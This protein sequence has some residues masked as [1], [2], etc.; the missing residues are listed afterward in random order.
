MILIKEYVNFLRDHQGLCKESIVIRKLH[1]QRFLDGIG[2]YSNLSKFRTISPPIIH[3]YI[4]KTIHN[5][6]RSNR[7]QVISS[8]RSFL[9][10]AYLRGFLKTNLV[11][12]VP[13]IRTAR[14][15][16][17]PRGYSW[18]SVKALLRA[19]DRTTPSGRRDYAIL[20]LLAS[21]GV[22]NRQ[23]ILLKLTDIKWHA[24]TIDFQSLKGGK[25]LCFPLKKN[26]AI[27]LLDY[28]KKD[29]SKET[30]FNEVFLLVKGKTRPLGRSVGYIVKMYHER[31]KLKNLYCGPHAIRHA[32]A[33]HLVE[34]NT[35][36]KTV[37]DLLGHSSIDTT[38]IYT[39]VDLKHLRV[40]A[41]QWPG[42]Q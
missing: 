32:F 38:F 41:R 20:Q 27:A 29:R 23:I 9:R 16:A 10:F 21:Y 18:K 12:S 36:I 17:L 14:L 24:G 3:K 6:S 37:S 34:Q 22:R 4:I 42:V 1:N 25:S 30:P 39:K 35:S 33:T 31:L 8:I 5:G 28:I 15:A 7:Q 11:E 40:L 2:Q 19:P 13:V 26:V